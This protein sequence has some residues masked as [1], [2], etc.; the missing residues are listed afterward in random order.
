MVGLGA[1]RAPESDEIES[2]LSGTA[3]A[4]DSQTFL[5]SVHGQLAECVD[6][7]LFCGC[8]WNMALFGLLSTGVVL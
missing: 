5:S 6:A 7:M 3:I 1:P 8:T 4:Y 2:L